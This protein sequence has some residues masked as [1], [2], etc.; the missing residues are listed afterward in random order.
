MSAEIAS[1]AIAELCQLWAKSTVGMAKQGR[2]RLVWPRPLAPGEQ[3]GFS[4]E[5]RSRWFE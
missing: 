5:P 4:V 3:H 2:A 1:G